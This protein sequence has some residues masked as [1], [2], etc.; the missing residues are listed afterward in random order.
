LSLQELAVNA[1]ILVIG[2]S[3]TTATALSAAT[4]FLG[5]NPE[6]L[7]K[8]CEEVR[9]AFNN[10]AEIDLFSVGRLNYMLAVLDEAMRLH[11]PVPATTPR[12]IS[13]LGDTIG[14]YY[15][16]LGVRVA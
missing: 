4:Y 15:V 6:P 3:E 9:S 13:E 12:T 5:M 14:G 7:K 10:E 11:A 16:P 8:L 1:G 2:G